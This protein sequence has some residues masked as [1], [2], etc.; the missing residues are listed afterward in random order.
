MAL[1]RSNSMLI[2]LEPMTPG[3]NLQEA[4]PNGNIPIFQFRISIQ[5]K[6]EINASF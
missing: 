5:E 3:L 6:K 2:T 4:D 1:E